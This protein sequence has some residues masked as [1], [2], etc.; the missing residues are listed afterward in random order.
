MRRKRG[1][2]NDTAM[3][4]PSLS[5]AVHATFMNRE[6]M[7]NY[8]RLTGSTLG[9]NI[10]SGLDLMID[11]ATGHDPHDQEWQ[12]FFEFVRDYVWLPVCWKIMDENRETS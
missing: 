3:R 1:P 4:F 9:L 6:F 5:E 12:P 2:T 10:R 8:R 11:H 7:A